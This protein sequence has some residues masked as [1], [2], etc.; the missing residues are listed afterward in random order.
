MKNS[1]TRT[2]RWTSP[3][4]F[5]VFFASIIIHPRRTT[6]PET[7]IVTPGNWTWIILFL[8]TLA[9]AA[10]SIWLFVKDAE[11]RED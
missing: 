10:T 5:I 4:I 1:L 6:D 3:I 11:E 2:G 7:G 9:S 8:L